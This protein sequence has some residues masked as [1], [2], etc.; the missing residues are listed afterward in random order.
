VNHLFAQQ[1]I[2]QWLASRARCGRLWGDRRY[3]RRGAFF[4]IFKLQ[5]ELLDGTVD[6]LRRVSELPPPQPRKL[7]LQLLD[8][9]VSTGQGRVLLQHQ[10][11]KLF[12]SLGKCGCIEHAV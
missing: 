1:M 7:H 4:K 6:L 3:S 9:A 5:L 12:G 8:D 10:G 2:G 11:T